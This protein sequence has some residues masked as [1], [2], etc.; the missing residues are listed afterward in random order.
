[1]TEFT[2]CGVGNLPEDWNKFPLADP[3]VDCLK[4]IAQFDIPYY[5]NLNENTCQGFTENVQF[6]L[7]STLVRI[8]NMK[9]GGIKSNHFDVSRFDDSSRCRGG[10]KFVPNRIPYCLINCS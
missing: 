1:M 4:A 6:P 7:I 8:G 9:K 5:Q 3:V 10:A 2:K